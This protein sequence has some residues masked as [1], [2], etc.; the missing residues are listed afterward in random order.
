MLKLLRLGAHFSS[1]ADLVDQPNAILDRMKD[2]TYV[3]NY[4][5]TANTGAQRL[6]NA[7]TVSMQSIENEAVAA[8]EE[9]MWTDQPVVEEKPAVQSTTTGAGPAASG[10]GTGAGIA[11]GQPISEAEALT[12]VST[13]GAEALQ[14]E[15]EKRAWH[16]LLLSEVSF[17]RS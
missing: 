12:I 10:N 11:E 16:K 15:A 2:G 5:L 14:T 3:I 9:A 6:S 17:V 1:R 8:A 13:R 4:S 7:T